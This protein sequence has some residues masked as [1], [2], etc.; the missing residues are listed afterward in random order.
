MEPLHRSLGACLGLPSFCLLLE[1]F[2]HSYQWMEWN[3]GLPWIWNIFRLYCKPVSITNWVFIQRLMLCPVVRKQSAPTLA[4]LFFFPLLFC[5]LSSSEIWGLPYPRAPCRSSLRTVFWSVTERVRST[6]DHKWAACDWTRTHL[7]RNKPC[8]AQLL[9]QGIKTL[10]RIFICTIIVL[11]SRKM[12][13]L[14]PYL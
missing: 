2:S 11:L 13:H 6:A 9:W 14:L 12:L 10:L 8:N 4:F 5:F 3:P 1:A 7:R